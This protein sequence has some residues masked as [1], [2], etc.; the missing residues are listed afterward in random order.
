[1]LIYDSRTGDWM[2]SCGQDM[3]TKVWDWKSRYA[4]LCKGYVIFI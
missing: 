1:M 2:L 4:D 3:V